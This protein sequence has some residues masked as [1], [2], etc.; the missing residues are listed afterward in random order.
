MRSKTMAIM[1][2]AV[3]FL[4]T[5]A[6]AQPSEGRAS[7]WTFAVLTI[8][9]FKH[10]SN[11]KRVPYGVFTSQDDCDMARAKKIVELDDVNFR[12]P[13]LTEMRQSLPPRHSGRQIDHY[14]KTSVR[15]KR[16]TSPI[17]LPKTDT[18][19]RLA[20][21]RLKRI[22]RNENALSNHSLQ[23]SWPAR[24]PV[25]QSSR[26]RSNFDPVLPSDGKL[27]GLSRMSSSATPTSSMSFRARP[28]KKL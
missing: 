26:I 19:L 3:L 15:A 5:V 13:H 20:A 14:G 1:A 23:P 11:I 9:Q 25:R 18:F 17:V 16:C 4:P 10:T 2:A 21:R 28:I 24:L 12:L 6:H 22:E 7:G 27:R 8:W